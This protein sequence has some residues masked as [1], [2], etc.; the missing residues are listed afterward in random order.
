MAVSAASI[1]VGLADSGI[2]DTGKDPRRLYSANA[3]HI[4]VNNIPVSHTLFSETLQNS[5]K[6]PFAKADD[7]LCGP[8]FMPRKQSSLVISISV[9][10]DYDN[11]DDGNATGTCYDSYY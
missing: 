10:T 8:R 5:K 6:C 11:D 3:Y 9:I 2:G 7:S 4:P 1:I